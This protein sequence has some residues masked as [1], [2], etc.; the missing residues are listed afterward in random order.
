MVDV[1]SQAVEM[2]LKEQRGSTTFLQR[3]L[4]IGYTRASRLIEAMEEQ[5]LVGPH[6][7]SK[8]RD[9]YYT[10]EQYQDLVQK[11]MEDKRDSGDGAE[12]TS[13]GTEEPGGEQNSEK[14]DGEQNSEEPGDK[15]DKEQ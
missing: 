6:V 9:V 12:D 4:G 14:P 7:G 2:V 15:P 3:Q 1:V 11:A 10:F 13:P 5:G 8:Q